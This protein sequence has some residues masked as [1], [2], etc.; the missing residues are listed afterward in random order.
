MTNRL[1]LPAAL[2]NSG[3]V[4]VLRATH[5][6][7]YA[8]VCRALADEGVVAVEVTLST[9]G[10][11]PALQQ[12]R[13]DVPEATFGV[14][15]VR[16]AEQAQAAI[17]AGADFL[18][19]PISNPAIV[20]LAV[21]GRVP[22]I[23]GALSPTEVDAMWQ[24]GASAVKIFPASVHGPGYLRDLAGPFPDIATVPSGGIAIEDIDHWIIAGALAVSLGGPLIGDGLQG[25][26]TEG[27]RRR[28][29]AALAAV[30][31]GRSRK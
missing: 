26:E 22:I 2:T 4:A 25:G 30:A 29:R 13:A 21:E 23:A 18:V 31:A 20:K 15:T 1:P 12:L 27:L 14:G 6:D 10:T 3:V 8:T 7:A 17:D 28:A 5:A 24:A 11:L 16:T 9:P 19:T